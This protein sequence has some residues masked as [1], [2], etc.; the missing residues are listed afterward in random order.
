[1]AVNARD[2]AVAIDVQRADR[3][4]LARR[5]PSGHPPQLERLIRCGAAGEGVDDRFGR[6]SLDRTAGREQCIAPSMQMLDVGQ[7]GWLVG[8]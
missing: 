7:A 2:G 3:D 5:A 4:D 1:V 8:A 6:P